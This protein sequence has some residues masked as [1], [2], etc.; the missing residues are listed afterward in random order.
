M[1]RTRTLNHFAM[2]AVTAIG[3]MVASAAPAHAQTVSGVD[4]NV[5]DISTQSCP[6]PG[7]EGACPVPVLGGPALYLPAIA[8]VGWD[9]AAEGMEL[10]YFTYEGIKAFFGL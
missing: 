2:F 7:T 4:G 3:L 1:K 9:L 5:C 6:Y 8:S 10:Y